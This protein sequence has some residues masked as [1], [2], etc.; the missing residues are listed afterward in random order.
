LQDSVDSYGNIGFLVQETTSE[1]YKAGVRL[2]ICGS[3]KERV[4]KP[5]QDNAQQS[6]Q[7]ELSAQI[8]KQ[9]QQI[10]QAEVFDSNDLPF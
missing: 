2:P 6:V 1:E 9:Q 10:K 3:V 4:S 7:V 5:V 8:A